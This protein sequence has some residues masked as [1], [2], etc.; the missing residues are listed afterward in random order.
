MNFYENKNV[1]FKLFGPLWDKTTVKSQ[2]KKSEFVEKH[3]KIDETWQKI[4]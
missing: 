1:T 2:Q 4:C 3:Q